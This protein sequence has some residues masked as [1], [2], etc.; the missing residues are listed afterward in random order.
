LN[1]GELFEVEHQRERN[2][3][4]CTVRLAATREINMCDTIGKGK[5]AIASETIEHERES[6]VA[7]D[8]ARAFEVFIE[9]GTDQIL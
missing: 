4:E 6:L 8:S 2:G 9:D 3:V 7:F 5:F 1:F